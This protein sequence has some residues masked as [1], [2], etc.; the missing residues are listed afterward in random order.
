M[1][2]VDEKRQLAARVAACANLMDIRTFSVGANLE[3]VPDGPGNLGYD[4]EADVEVQ[5]IEETSSLI[6]TGTYELQ[7][8]QVEH[9]EG[10]DNPTKTKIADLEF[11]MAALYN[12]DEPNENHGPF[13]D[14]ELDAFGDT[15]GQLALYPYAREFVSDLTN[16]MGL[17]TLHLGPLQLFTE[18]RPR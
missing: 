17:P 10:S 13:R 8:T 7:L 6:V 1:T 15:T 2:D 18:D 9:E 16:R 11:K 5:W 3:T 12:V 14:D 4:F